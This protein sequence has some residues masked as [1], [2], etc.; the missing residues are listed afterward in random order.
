MVAH[1]LT[2]QIFVLQALAAVQLSPLQ[3]DTMV[4]MRNQYLASVG[5]LS[6]RR[7][8]LTAQLQVCRRRAD[9]Q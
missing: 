7:R 2:L 8:Q 3:K 9:M 1:R 4:H 6:H 5:R